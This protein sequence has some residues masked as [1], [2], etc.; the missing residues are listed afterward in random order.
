MQYPLYDKL[1]ADARHKDEKNIDM[2]TLCQI[3]NNISLLD[4]EQAKDHYEEIFAIIIHHEKINHGG[5]ML[6]LIPNDGKLL[7]GGK[8]ILY[9]FI[10]LPKMLK[11]ILLAY[12]EHYTD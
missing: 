1:L 9:I 12:V 6:S 8:S 3:L 10:K 11:L 7:P 2:V 5:I 4:M